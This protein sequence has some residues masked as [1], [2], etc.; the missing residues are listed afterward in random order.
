M[1]LSD[2]SVQECDATKDSCSFKAGYIK[3]IIIVR[4]NFKSFVQT[5]SGTGFHGP[6]S[7]REG[8]GGEVN[9]SKA[10][11]ILVGTTMKKYHCCPVKISLLGLKP[12][13]GAGFINPSLKAGAIKLKPLSIGL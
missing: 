3:N 11:S 1:T 6:L 8:V 13:T 12:N 7:E 5:L 10:L 2:K 9:T 4:L